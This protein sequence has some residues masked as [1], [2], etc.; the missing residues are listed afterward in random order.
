MKVKKERTGKVLENIKLKEKIFLL[1]LETEEEISAKPGEFVMIKTSPSASAD[2]LL[3]RP[4]AVF[5]LEKR[6]LSVLYKITG[7]GT[8]L[9]STLKKGDAVQFSGPFGNSFPLPR[10]RAIFVAGGSGIA[11]LNFL[12]KKLYRKKEINLYYGV[13]SGDEAVPLSFLSFKPSQFLLTTEDGSEG[14]KGV[15]TDFIKFEKGTYYLA[16]PT[17]MIREFSKKFKVD[18]FASMEERMACGI[19]VCMGCG[20]L[21][22]EK[23]YRR[24]CVDGPVFKISEIQW[25]D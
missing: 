4:F 2:P 22:K 11:S 10:D 17:N 6:V 24:V 7:R 21:I 1:K 15:I 20:I 19:G 16:G 3:K 25:E 13:K 5:D 23:G 12:G 18:A 8:A 14:K 9:M